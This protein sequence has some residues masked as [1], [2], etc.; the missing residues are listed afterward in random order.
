M[1]LHLAVLAGY[2]L[3]LMALGLWIGRRVKGAADFFVAGRRLGPGLLFSTMLAANIGAG[4]TVGATGLAY[5]N[6]IAAWWWVGSAACGSIVLAFWIGPA[7]RRQAAAHDLRTVGDFL[8]FRFNASVRGSIATLVWIGSIFFLASQLIGLGWILNVVAGVPKPVGCVI[9]G[10][11]ITVY[12]AAG[13]LLTSAWVNVVQLSV[14]LVGFTIALPLIY[15]WAGGWPAIAAVRPLDTSFWTFFRPDS[16]GLM[17]LAVLGPAFFL[18]PGLLQKV[19]GARDDDAVRIGVGLNS[20]GLFLFAGVPVMLGVIARGHFPNL[21]SSNLALPTI[22]TASLPP[23]LGAVA[24]A[25]VFS[26]E[27]SAADASLFM[28]TTSLAQDL[29]RRFVNPR[30]D[31]DRVLAIAR[32][33]TVAS[34]AAGTA[35]AWVSE[36]VV[37]TLTIPYSLITV[38]LF[39][40]IVGGLY[41][42]RTSSRTALISIAAGVSVMLVVQ[43]ATGGAG[44]GVVT[45]ALAGLVAAIAAWGLSLYAD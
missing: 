41:T 3:A 44:R 42:K 24:L 45:P 20:I 16:S 21:A 25:A 33:A 8:E 18:S 11:V 34:G 17:N 19:F 1:S 5:T 7:I 29:Y 40:P 35:I 27:I 36:D 10:I 32:F 28:L 6:G 23:L 14:K 12:F 4:S 38:A 26:A 15:A 9:G 39:V 37:K 2:S 31:D 22:L 43:F 30:A 13:G